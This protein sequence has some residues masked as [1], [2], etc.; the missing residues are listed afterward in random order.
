MRIDELPQLDN[1]QSRLRLDYQVVSLMYDPLMEVAAY[2]NVDD[3]KAQRHP[4]TSIEDGH[5]A[6]HYRVNYHLRT[7]TGP[8]TYSAPTTVHFDLFANPDYPTHEPSCFVIDG[9]LPW[10]PHF[11]DNGWICIGKIWERAAGN[12]LV[13]E[14]LVHVAKL[15]NFD[16]PD[17][18]DTE[19]GGFRP[20][21]VNY[22]IGELN[23]QPITRNLHYPMIPPLIPDYVVE[24][25]PRPRISLKKRNIELVDSPAG[26]KSTEPARPPR[27]HITIKSVSQPTANRLRIKI[28]RSGK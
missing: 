13:G 26:M 19:Y 22:W 3:L 2:R 5:L 25:A 17:Y 8:G 6:T 12:M 9:K 20:E 11:A 1:L 16:E 18:V 4:I 14:L 7:L 24:T 28:S 10:S 21:A 27:A 15:L 23:R